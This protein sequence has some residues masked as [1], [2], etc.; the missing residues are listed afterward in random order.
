M[1]L[2]VCLGWQHTFAKLK[3]RLSPS[4]RC[5]YNQPSRD[6]RAA[7]LFWMQISLNTPV[8]RAHRRRRRR[9]LALTPALG[10]LDCNFNPGP[11]VT[12]SAHLEIANFATNGTIVNGSQMLTGD[13]SG[14]LPANLKFDKGLASTIISLTLL[15]EPHSRSR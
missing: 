13:A 10:A 9:R 1:Q 6:E 3:V 2:T 8:T 4:H 7:Y 5:S 12:Y 14:T 15:T 11:L